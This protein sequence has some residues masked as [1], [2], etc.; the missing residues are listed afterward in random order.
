MQASHSHRTGALAASFAVL[1]LISACGSG[2]KASTAPSEAASPSTAASA[3][4]STAAGPS[5]QPT[6]EAALDAPAEVAAGAQ[7]E[8]AW[9]GPNANG[10]YVTIVAAGAEKWTNEP[11]FYTNAASPGKLVAPV[12]DGDYELWYVSGADD[13]IMVRRDIKV[14][15]F[16]GTLDGPSEVEAG[17]TF[18]VAWTGPNGPSDY[19]TIVAVGAS[20]WTDEPY[21]YTSAGSTGELVA[22]IESGDYE[23]WYVTGNDRNPRLREPITVTP[24]VVTLQAPAS[25]KAGADF[26]VT[27]TGPDGPSDYIT[28][29]L[30]GSAPGTYNDYAYTSGGSPLTITAP[31]APGSYEIWY[32]SDRVKN[33]VFKSIPIIVN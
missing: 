23:L 33:L 18:E 29:V 13:T 11:Y 3:A 16:V 32:A 5:S 25:V 30:A 31:D 21:F 17:T 22:P 28:I 4:A 15:S 10:D 14:T 27:W 6:G 1:L 26:S 9:S 7:F 24:Y 19:V 12:A 2:G 8:V 20:Q